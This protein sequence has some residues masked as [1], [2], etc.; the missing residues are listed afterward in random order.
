MILM[1]TTIIIHK[2]ETITKICLHKG[3]SSSSSSKNVVSVLLSEI[4]VFDLLLPLCLDLVLIVDTG[5]ME[6]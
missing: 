1:H 3:Q 6:I 2:V 4:L 5:L